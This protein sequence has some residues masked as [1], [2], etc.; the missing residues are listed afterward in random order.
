MN[1]YNCIDSL[2]NE[3]I[4]VHFSILEARKEAIKR[5]KKK[6]NSKLISCEVDYSKHVL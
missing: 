1:N 2:G 5:L 4:I 6:Y 3:L